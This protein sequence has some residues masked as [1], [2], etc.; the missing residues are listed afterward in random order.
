MFGKTCFGAIAILAMTT[1]CT[2]RFEDNFDTD[3]TGAQP[4]TQPAGMP[5]DQLF[6][7]EGS[8]TVRVTASGAINGAKSMQ[9]R[10]PASRGAASNPIVFMYAEP[11]SD[12]TEPVYANWQGRLTSGASA[13]ISFFGGHFDSML[14]IELEER[15]GFEPFEL[16]LW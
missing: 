2:T 11:I 6:S 15:P 4:A 12:R 14:R 13:Q 16:P 7:L 3:T 10:G 9:M 1:A 8:G 5:D